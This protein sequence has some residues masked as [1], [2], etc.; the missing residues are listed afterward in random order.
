MKTSDEGRKMLYPIPRKLVKE[1]KS[2]VL[3]SPNSLLGLLSRSFENKIA[4]HHHKHRMNPSPSRI[5]PPLLTKLTN[6]S[7]IS[8]EERNP[9][10]PKA[11]VS[12]MDKWQEI[13]KLIKLQKGGNR[14]LS[15]EEVV[16]DDLSFLKQ[17]LIKKYRDE[18]LRLGLQ[19]DPSLLSKGNILPF[20][21]KRSF[22]R[23]LQKQFHFNYTTTLP[24]SPKGKVEESIVGFGDDPFAFYVYK[25]RNGFQSMFLDESLGKSTHFQNSIKQMAQE[26]AKLRNRSSNYKDGGE[27][28]DYDPKYSKRIN[29]RRKFRLHNHNKSVDHTRVADISE[30]SE[31]PAKDEVFKTGLQISEQKIKHT[32]AILNIG[33]LIKNDLMPNQTKFRSKS[34]LLPRL[35][36]SIGRHNKSVSVDTK[37]NLDSN[38]MINP[39]MMTE[40]IGNS[41]TQAESSKKQGIGV[42]SSSVEVKRYSTR[43]HD[44]FKK[45]QC[46]LNQLKDIKTKNIRYSCGESSREVWKSATYDL[47]KKLA[48]ERDKVELFNEEQLKYDEM[49]NLDVNKREQAVFKFN[50][51]MIYNQKMEDKVQKSI[52]KDQ[53]EFRNRF[54][55]P[56]MRSI[57]TDTASFKKRLIAQNKTFKDPKA[58]KKLKKAK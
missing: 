3:E 16:A 37:A 12:V 10:L 29:I 5:P 30:I 6:I 34:R 31:S 32:P 49:N 22:E 46:F 35:K 42:S 4:N 33:S 58:Q 11:K 36:M 14:M 51:T 15:V 45:I 55:I 21:E 13:G 17:K 57:I 54:T 7:E 47:R 48:E 44:N 56:A 27:V 20:I 50:N 2:P 41:G 39:Y 1:L 52:R 25:K 28:D 40:R 18:F 43:Q 24:V 19:E 53:I 8:Q 26:T 23:H 38:L 9:S